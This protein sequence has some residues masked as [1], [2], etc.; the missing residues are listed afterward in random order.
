VSTVT[1][2]I[3]TSYD[4]DIE[5]RETAERAGVLH[6][7]VAS[8]LNAHPLLIRALAESAAAQVDLPIDANRLHARGNGSADAYPL[9]PYDQRPRV[10][11]TGRTVR[12]VDCPCVGQPRRWNGAAADGRAD[13][14]PQDASDSEQPA[15]SGDSGSPVES[16]S[17]PSD[18]SR[19]ST[20]QSS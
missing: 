6:Y 4:L 19:P 9:R 10:N 16:A 3:E 5:L 20:P 7:E 17:S 18:E 12:C 13:S 15:S 14:S 8:A 11:G 2:Y 1:D